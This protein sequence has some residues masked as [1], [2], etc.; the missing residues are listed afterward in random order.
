MSDPSV[1]LQNAVETALRGSATLKSAM[2]LAVVRLYTMAA[3]VNA[4]FPYVLIGEDQVMDDST[5]C[6][7]SSEVITT[8]HVRSRV[9]DDVAAS[10]IQ[11]KSI[12]GVV[13]STIK[14]LSAVTGFDVVLADF[15]TTRHLIDP[16]GLT[17][18]SVVSHR[19]L[20]DP[21]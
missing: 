19:F 1:A 21:V 9:A 6:A 17:A 2:G 8:V 20:L 5:E 10:R 7:E 15:E 16:D 4:P 14:G 13:R 18:H 3:P 11:A 12:A